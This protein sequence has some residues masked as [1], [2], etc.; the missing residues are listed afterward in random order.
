MFNPYFSEPRE[1]LEKPHNTEPWNGL[2]HRLHNLDGDDL[3]LL[4]LVFLLI[5]EGQQE[6]RWP[7]VAALIY[8]VLT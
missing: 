6:E 2:M 5:R 1:A 3:F 8:C 7:L 4:L